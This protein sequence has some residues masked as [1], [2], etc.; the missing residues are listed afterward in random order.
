MQKKPLVA[1]LGVSFLLVGCVQQTPNTS[2]NNVNVGGN[3][4]EP[5]T[6]TNQPAAINQNTNDNKNIANEQP[7]TGNFYSNTK[8]GYKINL[9]DYGYEAS[10]NS[11]ATA[12]TIASDV[13]IVKR[14]EPLETYQGVTFRPSIQIS[15]RAR[16]NHTLTE[17]AQANYDLN[18]K[19][20]YTKSNIIDVTIGGQSAKQ[21]T[22]AGGLKTE[23]GE[24]KA[25]ERFVIYIIKGENL[26]EITLPSN[27]KILNQIMNSFEFT[28]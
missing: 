8:Y 12:A 11:F 16:N 26:F 5:T 18:K 1:L 7:I 25:Q 13:I 23:L 20:G 3:I 21:F 27:H 15:V 10:S 28:S 19:A 24:S 4:N 14:S 6:N 9:F 2:N 22:V 17:I